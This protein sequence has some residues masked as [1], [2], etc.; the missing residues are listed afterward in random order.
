VNGT[1]LPDRPVGSYERRKD[2]SAQE[3]L[4]LLSSLSVE[5]LRAGLE[6]GRKDLL[7]IDA[8][9]AMDH[10]RMHD[11]IGHPGLHPSKDYETWVQNDSES[12]RLH[13]HVAMNDVRAELRRRG[14][15]C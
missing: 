3:A 10:E 7:F 13:L 9:D 8:L 2:R 14:E 6:K 4:S 1:P 11:D 15:S 5:Q 12:R